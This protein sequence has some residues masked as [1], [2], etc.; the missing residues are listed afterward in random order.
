MKIERRQIEGVK[1]FQPSEV[2][3]KSRRNEG[4]SK[5]THSRQQVRGERSQRIKRSNDG[6][7][8]SEKSEDSRSGRSHNTRR[9]D[10]GG[11]TRH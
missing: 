8:R 6:R 10:G 9:S 3:Q 2:E 4:D 7:V 1:M 5:K 11:E